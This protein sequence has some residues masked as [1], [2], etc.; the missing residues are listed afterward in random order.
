MLKVN[1][2]TA[3]YGNIQ[4]LHQVSLEVH[5]GEVVALIG[6]NGA[7]K[8]TLLKAISGLIRPSQG[9]IEFLGQGIGRWLPERIAQNGLVMVPEGRNVFPLHS[10]EVNLEMGAYVR[11]D[12]NGIKEDLELYYEIFPPLKAMRKKNAGLLSGGEQQM[13]AISRALMSRPKCVLM[14][15][16]SMGLAPLLVKEIFK[17]IQSLNA[18][19]RTILLVEQNAKKALRVSQRAYVLENGRIALEGASQ[20]LLNDERV[21]HSYLGE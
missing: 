2:L 5:E 20:D 7:G 11:T 17:T 15:E 4:V 12:R 1:G 14:D 6:A 18:Q 19:G 8:S 16:P 21:R 13:L 9:T 3:H 10:V